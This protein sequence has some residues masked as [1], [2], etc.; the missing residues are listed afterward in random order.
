MKNSMK[1]YIQQSP[2]FLAI[3]IFAVFMLAPTSILIEI[4]GSIPASPQDIG[5]V[6]TSFALGGIAGRLTAFLYNT[7]FGN[8]TIMLAAFLIL[9]VLNTF[10]FLANALFTLLAVY[11]LSGYVLGIVYIQANTNL[12][13]SKIKDK[14]RLANLAISFYP[15]GAAL[16]PLASS[17]LVGRGYSWQSI[18]LLMFPL[19]ILAIALLF[20]AEPNHK[21]AK[22]SGR[23]KLWP[24][25]MLQNRK[26]NRTY[27]L[28]VLII[29]TYCISEAVI[30]T[31]APTFLRTERFLSAHSAGLAVTVF[32]FAVIG[33]RVTISAFTSRVSSHKIMLYISL[34]G[35][36]SISC[37]LFF[38]HKNVILVLMGVAGLGYSGMFPLLLASGSGIF[39]QGKGLVVTIIFASSSLAKALTPYLVRLAV[40][41]SMLL[42]MALAAIF[43]ALTVLLVIMLIIFKKK[44][45]PNTG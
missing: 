16:G 6:L 28:V 19:L 18:Y 9:G 43:M 22:N 13:E 4:S 27:A 1:Q 23:K 38:T 25:N 30:F 12:M 31:W 39:G 3:F 44:L 33:G 29:L 7:R 26:N 36:L 40:R 10:L 14:A 11:A 21:K 24:A 35:F 15:L 8:R 20:L 42:S 2:N 41:S 34:V 45:K 32:W 5:F 17:T 37:M